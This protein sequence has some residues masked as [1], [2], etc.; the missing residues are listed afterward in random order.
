MRYQPNTK[1]SSPFSIDTGSN[2]WENV[3][4]IAFGGPSKSP[5]SERVYGRNLREDFNLVWVLEGK[6]CLWQARCRRPRSTGRG[7]VRPTDPDGVTLR[8]RGGRI[9]RQ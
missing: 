2:E 8:P 4:H 6:A 5:D 9:W 7:G 3:P 1:G